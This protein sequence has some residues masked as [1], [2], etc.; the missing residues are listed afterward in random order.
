VARWLNLVPGRA[1]SR[2][3]VTL[4]VIV[5]VLTT[6]EA[7]APPV[8]AARLT[9]VPS[10]QPA[11]D[12]APPPP[13]APQQDARAIITTL[14]GAEVP[15]QWPLGVP[16][17]LS[18][19]TSVAGTREKSVIWQVDPPWVDQ[20]SARTENNRILSVGTGTRPKRIVVVL[21]VAKDD[22]IDVAR[23]VVNA[24]PD[25]TEPG[26]GPTPAPV[27]TPGP[28]PPVPTPPLPGPNL[29]AQA[30]MVHDLVL[31]HVADY[32]GR[33]AMATR[34]GAVYAAA[35]TAISRAAALNPPP[36]DLEP[37]TTPEG[38]VKATGTTIRET[39]GADIERWRGFFAELRIYLNDLAEQGKLGS[40]ADHVPV[41]EDIEAGLKSV[42]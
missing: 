31:A 37:Y 29:S 17:L 6:G 30:Q 2:L 9:Q 16:M 23:V 32:P 7:Q 5:S 33:K 35:L 14:G 27:P 41:F 3:R 34:L 22:T 4:L 10:P 26:D 39:L 12:P 24:V 11:P 42:Q 8:V 38:I 25:P 21:M 40:A 18:A 28:V 13:F 20:N 1:L 15:P 36:A 19:K